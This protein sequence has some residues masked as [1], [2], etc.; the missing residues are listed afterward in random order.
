M[1]KRLMKPL[2]YRPG[3]TTPAV[4]DIIG[5][6]KTGKPK[7]SAEEKKIKAMGFPPLMAGM[8]QK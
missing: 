1:N 2:P 7:S 8:K 6:P 5:T 4:V 3:G